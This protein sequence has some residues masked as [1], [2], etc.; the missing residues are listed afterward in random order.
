MAGLFSKPDNR[1]AEQQMQM[2]REENAALREQTMAERRDLAEQTA[3][4]TRAKVRGGSRML[5]SAERLTPETG[6]MQTLGS[7]TGKVG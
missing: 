2:Q 4:R 1:A 3:A 7:N 6:V 5:L